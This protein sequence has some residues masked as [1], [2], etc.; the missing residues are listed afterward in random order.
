MKDHHYFGRSLVVLLLMGVLAPLLVWA[1]FQGTQSMRNSPI[2]WIPKTYEQRQSFEWFVEH[3]QTPEYI[4]MSWEG[5]TVDDQRLETLAELL[6]DPDDPLLKTL[7]YDVTTG[8]SALR[9]LRSSPVQLSR[10]SAIKRLQGTLVGKDGLTSCAVVA[11]TEEGADRGEESRKLILKIVQD[12][13]KVSPNDC[14]LAGSPIDGAAIDNAS[15]EAISTF[16]IPSTIV[17]LL[18]SRWCLRSWP[19]TLT[20]ILTALFGQALVLGMIYLTGVTMNAVLTVTAPLV[21]V[22]TVSAGVHLVNY[23]HDEVRLFGPDG[24]AR[25]ALKTGWAP[26]VLAAITTAAGLCSLIVS[27]IIPAVHFGIY[28]SLA[29][30]A[31]TGLLFA[32]LPGPMVR[33]PVATHHPLKALSLQSASTKTD[34]PLLADRCSSFVHRF[35]LI[36][37]IVCIG[38]MVYSI[39]GLIRLDSSVKVLNM[40]VPQSR[41]VRDYRWLESHVGPMVP[42]E[43]VLK[44]NPESRLNMLKRLQIVDWAQDKLGESE[45]IDGTLSAA[46][47]FPSIPR[48]G[49]VRKTAA[50]RVLRRQLEQ[51][52]ESL[53]NAHYLQGDLGEEQ[54]WRISARAPALGNLDYGLYLDELR[55]QIDPVLAKYNQLEQDKNGKGRISAT[56]TGVMP[57]VYNVQRSMLKDLISSYLTALI[58]VGIIMIVVLRSV[59]AGLVA[60]LP[61]MFPTFI[62]F[63]GMGWFGIPLDIGSMMTAGVALGIAVDGT[64]H[65]LNWFRRELD[66]GHSRQ[67]AVSHTFR[68]CARAIAQTAFI[69]GL[70][71]LVYAFSD[72]VPTRRFAFMMFALLLAACVGDLLFLPALLVGPLGRLFVRSRPTPAAT[73]P[74]RSDNGTGTTYSTT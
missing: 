64:L 9:K 41:T 4:T 30:L 73:E 52:R 50:R 18:L 5:C 59:G 42:I 36:I 1:T 6:T 32:V 26:C 24:A 16:M 63:G 37:S 56:Y 71:L 60:M 39:G 69:C 45:Q 27:D 51:Q 10:E 58:L 23:Y 19:L 7:V 62:L 72:F 20:V 2:Q 55:Q 74:S 48:G 44:F 67:E 31:T 53:E 11:L 40:L 47:F 46:S 21:Y 22:L 17:V 14:F 49:G 12:Q 57:L 35:S 15:S 66:A 33:W 68:H 3:F 29:L 61:N 8:Y 70:G 43:I 38:W 54:A 25:R 13:L 28:A 34:P 65:F